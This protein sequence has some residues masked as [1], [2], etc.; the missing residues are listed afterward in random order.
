MQAFADAKTAMQCG[1]IH[2]THGWRSVVDLRAL[3][4]PPRETDDGQEAP[5]EPAFTRTATDGARLVSARALGENRLARHAWTAPRACRRSQWGVPD[6]LRQALRR[7]EASPPCA[8]RSVLVDTR[9]V[10]N[11]RF[12]AFVAAT[13]YVT[14]AER[15]LNLEDYPSARLELAIAGD[16]CDRCLISAAGRT[17]FF[18]TFVR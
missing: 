5:L 13:G 7:G 18:S 11:A 9:S 4:G 14:T 16:P 8:P 12:A 6:G 1:L 3:E 17:G 2:P 10:T 15:P